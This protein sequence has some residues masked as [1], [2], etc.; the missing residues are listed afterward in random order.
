M[1]TKLLIRTACKYEVTFVIVSGQSFCLLTKRII[2]TACQD[3]ETFMVV[4]WEAFSYTC[5]ILCN[6]A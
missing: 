2:L 4:Q 5:L 6:L 3:E 1:L